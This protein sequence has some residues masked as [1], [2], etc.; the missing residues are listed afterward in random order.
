MIDNEFENKVMK[1][2]GNKKFK[3][4][5]SYT[6]VHAYRWCIK[7]KLFK[8]VTEKQFRRIIK[9]INSALKEQLTNGNDVKLPEFMGTLAIRKRE[10]KRLIGDDGRLIVTNPVDWK[11]TIQLWKEDE[12][13]Y[14]N[15]TLLRFENEDLFMICYRKTRAKYINKVF[16][17]FSPM[18]DVK[19]KLKKSI[20]NGLDSLMIY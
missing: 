18:R 5:N 20:D 2:V 11:N 19:R 1:K 12:E 13:A 8:D 9:S 16:I 4:T 14:N 7:N 15:K 17:K 6:T 3:I 10:N